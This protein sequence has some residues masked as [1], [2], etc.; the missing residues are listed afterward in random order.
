MEQRKQRV[1]GEWGFAFACEPQSLSSLLSHITQ[2]Q[3]AARL[4]LIKGIKCCSD[5]QRVEP[6]HTMPAVI[7]VFMVEMCGLLS[8]TAMPL[9]NSSLHVR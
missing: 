4:V 8:M 7:L 6:R 1:V 2:A 9:H 5:S 3:D